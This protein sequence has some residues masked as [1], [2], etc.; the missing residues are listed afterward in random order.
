MDIERRE[1]LIGLGVAGGVGLGVGTVAWRRRDTTPATPTAAF[2]TVIDAV[3]AGADPDGEEPI[4]EM[5]EAYAG[6]NTLLVFPDGTYR[7]QPITLEGYHMFGISGADGAQPTFLADE[8]H[9]VG[10]GNSFLHLENVEEFLLD[11]I[12]FDFTDREAGGKIRITA[13][14]DGTVSNV[15]ATGQCAEQVAQFRVD[16]VDDS[17]TAVIY[18][19]ELEGS[20]PDQ[21]LTG[22]FVGEQ[23]A[24][25]LVFRDCSIEGFTDNGLYASAPGLSD[26]AGGVVTVE[27]GT[28]RNNNVANVRLGSAGS[29]ASGVKSISNSPPPSEGEVNANARGF[30]LRSGYGQLI[31]DCDV[32]ISANSRFTH[33]GIVFHETNGGATVENTRIE[34][35]RDDTP[36]IR[37]FPKHNGHPETAAFE[38]VE[39]TGDAADGQAIMI[40]NR[41]ETVF[42]N[43][44]IEQ[45]GAE[46]NGILFRDSADC[47]LVD[48]TI[49]VT[50]YPLVVENSTVTVENTTIRTPDETE[51]I[52]ELEATDGEY[53]PRSDR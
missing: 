29:V 16:V 2:D 31:E 42:R 21:W 30:R 26:G 14:G 3:D 7:L 41:D 25:E 27:G 44:T 18:G 24:G 1:L 20:N 4:N 50:D 15:H 32:E 28:Y 35:N 45:S 23:H 8:G 33:G 48:S 12:R 37:L 40:E 10:G 6:D 5:L 47:R 52:E 11:Q 38:E 53:A 22:V 43:C 49:T 39:I 13:T 17:A 19:L 51:E 36:A 46:R 9:C 34:I